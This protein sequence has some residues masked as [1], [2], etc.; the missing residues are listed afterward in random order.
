MHIRHILALAV[1]AGLGLWGTSSAKA[2]IVTTNT[3]TSII[4]TDTFSIPSTLVHVIT[5][6]PTGTFAP[7]TSNSGTLTSVKI[8]LTGPASADS[9]IFFNDFLVDGAGAVFSPLSGAQ[10]FNTSPFTFALSGTA[11]S[12]VS[13]TVFTATGSF[14]GKDP[15]VT[16][17]ISG[18]GSTDSANLSANSLTEVLTYNFTPVPTAAPEPASIVL[19]GAGLIAL[20]AIR[21]GRKAG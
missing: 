14:T 11:T 1:G 21:R 3:P 6:I 20:G 2:G 4:Q 8:T 5:T 18:G 16:L 17:E 10:F 13:L 7:F 19:F 15:V 9:S 12:A